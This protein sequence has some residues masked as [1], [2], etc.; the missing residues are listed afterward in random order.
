MNALE[1]RDVSFVYPATDTEP[2]L[3]PV[4]EH[5][6][7]AVPEGAFALLTGGTGSGKSTLLR[8]AKLE[9]APTGALSGNVLA[10]GKELRTLSPVESAQTVSLVF[11]SPD[12][13]IVC[14]TVWH[15][16]AFGLENLGTPVPEMRRRV[17]E[18]C[19]FFGVEPWFRRQTASLSGGQR[20]MLALAATLAMRPRLLLLDE[21]T[22]M[23]DPVAEKD[24][25]AMLFRANRELGVT[26]VVATHDPE[27]MRDVAT[28]AFRVDG[29]RVREL[30]LDEAVAACAFRPE[31]VKRATGKPVVSRS[32]SA[33]SLRDAWFRYERNSDWVLRGLD[34]SAPEGQVTAIVGGNGSGKTTLLQL[35][36][37][38]LAPQRGRLS[39]P[40]AASQA[41]LPQ[42]P[43][44][45]LSAQTVREELMFWSKGAG[46][47]E[48][49]VTA[50]MER[51]GLTGVSAR[52]PLDLS[53]GQQQLV[54][55]AKLLLTR[56]KLL[57]LDEPT[58]GLDAAARAKLAHLVLELRQEGRGVLLATHDLAFV[59]AVADSVSLL[60]DGAVTCTERPDEFLAGSWLYHA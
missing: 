3:T 2:S 6:S 41:Y 26:V 35:A 25:L 31:A 58:K 24:F 8:L 60:F 10:F 30:P 39:R 4:L 59:A 52:N 47:A 28:C 1:L 49:D 7:M 43:R 33:L 5:V 11:Q 45:I 57:I 29:G 18:T 44:A 46:Y 54:A 22:S 42:S 56:P 53:G 27:P 32:K 23:L 13:Q 17:A 15:E 20:Q 9:V 55:F 14:D 16:M 40:H 51:L 48:S 21:P 36:C 12:S 19:M 37:G 34:L 38:V 50:M